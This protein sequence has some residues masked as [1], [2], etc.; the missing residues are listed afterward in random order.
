[1]KKTFLKTLVIFS[2]IGGVAVTSTSCKK[3][4]CTSETATN[5]DPEAQKDDG[6]CVEPEPEPEPEQ[7]P[8]PT[9]P[10]PQ[11]DSADAVFIA[12]KTVTYAANPLGGS[13]ETP[14]GLPVAF[15]LN[16]D[17]FDEMGTVKC[18]GSELDKQDNNSYVFI[19]STT[20]ATGVTYSG[21]ID[22][23]ISGGAGLDAHTKS[24]DGTFPSGLELTTET[25]ATVS[26]SSSF[27]LSTTGSI[28]D[29]D[30][31]I[32]AVHGTSKSVLHTV[33]GTES[34]YTFTADE[35]GSVGAGF[36]YIQVAAY[37]VAESEMVG[38]KK[39]YYLNETVNT[40]VV[41]LE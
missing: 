27:T 40:T 2:L 24:S 6:S 41:T 14:I 7:A 26:T 34:S 21:D 13:I 8:E 18:E 33:A 15:A 38:S 9:N 23:E 37:R 30:S 39:V 25:N 31:V 1:M 28:S 5:F 22:W 36:G 32:F 3:K 20:D 11:P 19:P 35:M 4:G 17:N 29:A 12:L 16:G 10:Q